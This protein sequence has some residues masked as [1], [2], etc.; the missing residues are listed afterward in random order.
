[1][2]DDLDRYCDGSEVDLLAALGLAA[3][4][5]GERSPRTVYGQDARNMA[6]RAA[7]AMLPEPKSARVLATEFARYYASGWKAD[8][9]CVECPPLRIGT[10][11][12]FY[13]RALKSCTRLVGEDHIRRNIL[14]D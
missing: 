12:E 7:F 1:L 3:S 5:P 9:H 13:W 4:A 8:S 11:H 14:S 2:A 6:L 10:R